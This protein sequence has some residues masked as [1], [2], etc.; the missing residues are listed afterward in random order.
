M[1]PQS[2]HA[3]LPTARQLMTSSVIRLRADLPMLEAAHT[4]AQEAV[5]GAPVVDN[6]GVLVGV[7][8]EEDV[9]RALA[10][11]LVY[12]QREGTVGEH[13]RGEAV[14]VP[15]DAGLVDLCALMAERRVKRLLVIEGGKMVGLIARRDLMTALAR[16]VSA[17]HPHLTESTYAALARRWG[18]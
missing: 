3:P 9:M 14:T 18:L 13:L 2:S 1:T 5:S 15:P 6:Q 8:S 11:A 12:D 4:L 10:A 17:R 7:F 16:A